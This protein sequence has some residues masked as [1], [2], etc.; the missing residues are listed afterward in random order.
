VERTRNDDPWHPVTGTVV[1]AAREGRGRR[2]ALRRTAPRAACSPSTDGLTSRV[3]G[4]AMHSLQ[5]TWVDDDRLFFWA[6][7]GSPDLALQTDL[8]A[9]AELDPQP[10][11]R[12][13]ARQRGMPP[14]RV[15]G[16]DVE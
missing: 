12:R 5:A 11:T 8:P 13:V 2:R 14:Q 15:R 6:T 3:P 1:G 10:A 9:V 4:A 16:Y 7:Q